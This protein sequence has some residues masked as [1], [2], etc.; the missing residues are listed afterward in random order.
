MRFVRLESE[1]FCLRVRRGQRRSL[2]QSISD[3][4]N[5]FEIPFRRVGVLDFLRD[6]DGVQWTLGR[7]LHIVI[8]VVYTSWAR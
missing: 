3:F 2:V 5:N 6:G 8:W 7:W 4:K 1:T